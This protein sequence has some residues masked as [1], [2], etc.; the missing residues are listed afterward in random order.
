MIQANNS[1]DLELSSCDN[2]ISGFRA[3][4]CGTQ[5][6]AEWGVIN[7]SASVGIIGDIQVFNDAAHP[8][9]AVFRGSMHKWM[10]DAVVNVHTCDSII[11]A[12]PLI[13]VNGLDAGIT[14]TPESIMQEC[15]FDITYSGVT[16]NTALVTTTNITSSIDSMYR[17]DITIRLSRPDY[18]AVTPFTGALVTNATHFT[19]HGRFVDL[20]SGREVSFFFDKPVGFDQAGKSVSTMTIDNRTGSRSDLNMEMAGTA[21]SARIQA[22]IA[23][24]LTGYLDFNKSDERWRMFMNGAVQW[25]FTNN[26]IFPS[27]DGTHDMG[28]PGLNIDRNFGQILAL[29]DGITAPSTIATHAQLY[30]DTADGDLKIKFGDGTVKTIVTDT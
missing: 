20:P 30:V 4:N 16:V 14:S 15:S 18:V 28:T 29:V 22:L 9:G 11:D 12:S 10:V 2:H 7:S 1:R 13:A 8:V 21:A 19:N 27:F 24:V 17:N 3:H 26:A 6:T 5:H 25:Q 23:G